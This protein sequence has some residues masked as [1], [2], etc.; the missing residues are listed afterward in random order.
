MRS[1][2]QRQQRAGLPVHT[3]LKTLPA[4]ASV[5]C[6]ESPRTAP[7]PGA[8][9]AAARQPARSNRKID[10][11]ALPAARPRQSAAGVL[12]HACA[13]THKRTHVHRHCTTAAPGGSAGGRAAAG[14]TQRA[15]QTAMAQL[16]CMDVVGGLPAPPVRGNRGACDI[17]EGALFAYAAGSGIAVVE[18]GPRGSMHACMHACMQATR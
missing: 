11:G 5:E 1:A 10:T 9:A 16:A 12:G 8:R 6:S 13:H 3:P 15:P 4:R 17:L 7:P 14:T 2:Q 18:V